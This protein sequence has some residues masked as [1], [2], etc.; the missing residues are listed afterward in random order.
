MGRCWASQAMRIVNADDL[1]RPKGET[2]AAMVCYAKGRITSTS[3]I[4]FMTDS[5]RASEAVLDAGIEV[6]M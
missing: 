4:A 1:G 6:C 5:E 2:D 3:A